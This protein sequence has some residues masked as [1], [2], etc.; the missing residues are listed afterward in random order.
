MSQQVVEMPADLAALIEN[1]VTEDDTPVDNLFSEK[2]QR[3]LTE[4]LY[5]SWTP[6]ASADQSGTPRPFLAAANVGIFAS[7]Y[8]PPLVPD[9]FLSLDVQVAKDW[10]EHRHRSYFF[11]EY[12]KAPEVVV[13]IVSNR[14][15][16]ETGSKLRDYARLGVLYYVIFDPTH[17]LSTDVLHVYEL[18]VGQYQPRADYALP[19][20]GLGC[21]L[22]TGSYEGQTA[23]WL[24][25][26]D[27]RRQLIPSG[28]ERAA[29][30]AERAQREA[31]RA[32][33]ATERAE[34]EAERAQQATERAEREA[35]RAQQAT[36]RAERL[37]AQLRALGLDPEQL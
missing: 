29:H 23:T 15:G 13:E 30:E 36:E 32:Q 19:L 3:L 10:Y 37:A 27:A 9:V 20:I 1:I 25:W 17:Q 6:P 14:K 7:V 35:E 12:G 2:Q 18:Q 11:W 22:W 4:A 26:C 34:R 28:A 33:Q 8:Q 31:E 24:R 21:M 5:S 16:N